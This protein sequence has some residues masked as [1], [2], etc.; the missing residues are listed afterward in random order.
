MPRSSTRARL[1]TADQVGRDGAPFVPGDPDNLNPTYLTEY[2]EDIRMFGAS[3]DTRLRAAQL[4]GEFTYRPNQPLQY[5][6]GRSVAAVSRDGA[7]A[8]AREDGRR[9]AGRVF[10]GWERHEALQLQLGA[11]GQDS[12]TS[13]VRSGLNC[14]R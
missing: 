8:V 5:N 12:R 1:S 13:W 3:F 2:P 4:L 11:V 14:S 9:R 10:H 6:S 7:D